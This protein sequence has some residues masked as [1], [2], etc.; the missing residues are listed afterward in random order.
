MPT[1][2][3]FRPASSTETSAGF[4]QLRLPLY[5]ELGR[6]GLFLKNSAFADALRRSVTKRLPQGAPERMAEQ[7]GCRV[8]RIY[9]ETSGDVRYSVDGFVTGLM[10]LPRH[11]A[12]GVLR[13]IAREI[14]ALVIEDPSLDISAGLGTALRHPNVTLATSAT[15]F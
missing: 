6:D 1:R 7:L 12:R 4:C 2:S 15:N 11:E 13:K 14:D 8:A 9:D 5:R 10:Q 3:S